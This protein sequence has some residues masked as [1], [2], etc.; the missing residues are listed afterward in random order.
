MTELLTL[1]SFLAGMGL[2]VQAGA[3]ARLSQAVGTPFAATAVQLAV[4]TAI[5]LAAAFL[6]GALP[7]LG[8]L[9]GGPW[10]HAVGGTVSAVYVLAVILVAPRLGAI[11]AIGVLITGQ[12]FGSLLLDGFGVLGVSYR[13]FP[14]AALI[15]AGLTLLGVVAL[16]RG[17][18]GEIS[19]LR[20]RPELVVLAFVAGAL[21]PI[22]GAVNALLRAD[23]GAPLAVGF[24][25]FLVATA[26]TVIALPLIQAVL[27]PPS[28]RFDGLTAM[29]A[30]GWLGGVMGAF[31]VTTVFSAI[32]AIGAASVVAL[33]VAGQ[34]AA[35]VL[36]DQFGLFGFP[37]RPITRVRLGGVV[38]MFAGVGVIQFVKG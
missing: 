25:S 23:I 28:P 9:G 16:V 22:Q 11:V 21:L 24:V 32:P 20:S 8:Q 2:A 33:T 12:T 34:Q 35:S 26:T 4:G 15:G 19:T 30:W 10:W 36:V 7:A 38:L 5:L 37:K 1:L 17:Q 18:A 29:P 31:Y 3:N 13:G 14:P 6:F 27:H